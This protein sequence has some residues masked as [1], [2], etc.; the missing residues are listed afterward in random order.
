[1]AASGRRDVWMVG[2]NNGH[3][4]VDTIVSHLNS[5]E[6]MSVGSIVKLIGGKSNWQRGVS[7]EVMNIEW[8]SREGG[9]GSESNS[10]E[11]NVL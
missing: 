8:V 2:N 10:F 11:V 5:V 3:V 7:V 1:M 6:A 9:M 4:S